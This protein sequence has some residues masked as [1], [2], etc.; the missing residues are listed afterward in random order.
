[1]KTLGKK[2]EAGGVLAAIGN[3]PLIKMR[4]IS[5][6]NA[7][8]ILAKFEG[9]N[10]GGSIKDRPA[11]YM[12]RH[13]IESGELTPDKVILEPTSGN[14]GIGL[15]MVGVALGYKVKLCMPQCVSMERR[16]TLEAFGAE[17]VLTPGCEGTDGAIIKAREMLAENPSIYYMPDQF[18]NPQNIL[19]HYETTAAEIIEQTGGSIAAFVAGLG[20]TGTIMGISRRLR[21]FNPDIRIFAVEPVLGH[22]IQGLKNMSESIVPAIYEPSAIDE[23]ITVGDEEAFGACRDLAAREGLFCGM[24]SGAALAGALRVARK[25]TSGNVVTVFPDRGDRYLSTSLYKSIC[26]KCPP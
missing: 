2:L 11:L 7:V 22:T 20:T 14:T 3:T 5:P 17:L 24:S 12:L 18:S 15:A 25:F 13:A 10:P 8:R 4:N 26:A 1:M 19:S 21:E 6:G 23:I 9:A 16:S